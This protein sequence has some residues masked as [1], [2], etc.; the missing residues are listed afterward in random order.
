M[1]ALRASQVLGSPPIDAT[2]VILTTGGLSVPQTGSD[3]TTLEA[4]LLQS[5]QYAWLLAEVPGTP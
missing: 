3:G 1:A 4:R 5:G 2:R